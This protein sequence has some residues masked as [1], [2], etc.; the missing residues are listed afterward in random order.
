MIAPTPYVIYMVVLRKRI[1]VKTLLD[2][3]ISKKFIE[4]DVVTRGGLTIPFIGF[5]QEYIN[6]V[7]E[8][9]QMYYCLLNPVNIFNEEVACPGMVIDFLR[10]YT[11]IDRPSMFK[12][13]FRL[14]WRE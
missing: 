12:R 3:G 6:Y 7:I 14:L 1:S 4:I 5:E 10:R 11:I 9:E 13:L 8:S 2:Q